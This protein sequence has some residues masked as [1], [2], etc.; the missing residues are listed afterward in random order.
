[1]GDGG[2][3]VHGRLSAA[4]PGDGEPGGR[5]SGGK[6]FGRRGCPRPRA[7]RISTT[8]FVSVAGGSASV[9]AATSAGGGAGRVPVVRHL[10]KVD[11][12][13]LV[14]GEEGGGG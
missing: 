1:M 3:R 2:V 14:A 10:V 12:L 11:P 5:T 13:T 4:D 9:G 8:R 7:D 6:S